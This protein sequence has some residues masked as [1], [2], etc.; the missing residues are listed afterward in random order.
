MPQLKKPAFTNPDLTVNGEVVDKANIYIYDGATA[1]ADL[2]SA[3]WTAANNIKLQPLAITGDTKVLLVN[4]NN[5]VKAITAPAYEVVVTKTKYDADVKEQKDLYDACNPLKTACVNTDLP[6]AK[7]QLDN[8]KKELTAANAAIAKAKGDL[9]VANDK[10]ANTQKQLTDCTGSNPWYA[11]APL[12][13]VSVALGG[14]MPPLIAQV[15][16]LLFH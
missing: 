1:Y 13:L 7:D 8:A 14:L 6:A 12:S 5:A 9:A 10:I 2:P 3:T 4:A 16:T 11:T 15:A